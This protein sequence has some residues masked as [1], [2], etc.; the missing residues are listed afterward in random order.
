MHAPHILNK[1]VRSIHRKQGV[2]IY[3]GIVYASFFIPR[4][5]VRSIHRKQGVHIYM[6]IVYASFLIPRQSVRSIHRKQGVHIY[7]GIVYASFFIPRQSV[8]SIHR[9]SFGTRTE[10][11]LFMFVFTQQCCGR[12]LLVKLGSTKSKVMRHKNSCGQRPNL[13]QCENECGV[14]VK[15]GIMK[16]KLN[17]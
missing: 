5:S 1:K 7:I 10:P 15:R 4:Q 16:K 11:R 8:R 17:K 9:K 3:M 12:E 13:L 6:G 2:H 14:I